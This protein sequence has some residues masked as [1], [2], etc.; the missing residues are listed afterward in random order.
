MKIYVFAGWEPFGYTRITR[1]AVY[2]LF[3][4]KPV[5]YNKGAYSMSSNFLS[6][7]IDVGSA[8]SFMSIVNSYG[9]LVLNLLRFFI[10][11]RILLKELL[12]QLK[13][14]KSLNPRNP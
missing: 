1:Q 13:K 7:G 2:S 10:M 12:L 4:W 11:I 14:Q 8:F 6:V 9:N 5:L 3:V